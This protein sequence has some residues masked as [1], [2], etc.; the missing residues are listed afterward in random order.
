[1]AII[2]GSD[3]TT[4]EIVQAFKELVV[5]KVLKADSVY[6]HDAYHAG[7]I[8]MCAGYQ[9]VPTE[10]MD[11]L[12]NLNRDIDSMNIGEKA[13]IVNADVILRGLIGATQALSRVG[14][15]AF[16][17]NKTHSESGA[18][19][20]EDPTVKAA[21]QKASNDAAAAMAIANSYA[22]TKDPKYATAA[23]QAKASQAA[24]EK[25]I[26]DW[27]N[28][29]QNQGGSG[30]SSWTELIGSQTGKVIFT[31]SKI[32]KDLGAPSDTANTKYGE[33]IRAQDLNT[34]MA[35]FYTEW[36][37]HRCDPYNGNVE[38]CHTSCHFNCHSNCHFNCHSA[39][40]GWTLIKANGF[41]DAEGA[42]EE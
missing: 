24:A 12:D 35:N 38:V 8:P 9:A 17:V 23:A 19:Y 29:H 34:L 39:C 27:K 14:N 37:N 31:K 40:H 25:A 42:C 18:S 41:M 6:N 4:E 13:D 21:L 1:M 33:I 7:D 3:I 16:T 15:F 26:Q 5:N 36:A 11:H 32:R 30:G 22:G 2:A 28:A 20:M 10:K